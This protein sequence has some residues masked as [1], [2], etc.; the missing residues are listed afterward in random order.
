MKCDGAS[1]LLGRAGG[2]SSDRYRYV[3]MG[4]GGGW[5][6]Y[7]VFA[8]MILDLLDNVFILEEILVAPVSRQ[9]PT[10]ENGNGM[11]NQKNLLRSF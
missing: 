11:A 6:V 8:F 4:A 2:Y 5:L 9:K 1:S 3:A 7:Q 10:G